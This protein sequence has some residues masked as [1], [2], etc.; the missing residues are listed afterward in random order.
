MKHRFSPHL[1]L[2]LGLL[3]APRSAHTQPSP[4]GSSL[5][6][7]SSKGI[8]GDS[9]NSKDFGKL[10]TNI[11]SDSLTVN[12]K[13]RV[14]T[15][16]G[17]VVVTQGDLTLTSKTVDGTY[18]EDNQIQKIVAR[19]DVVITKQDIKTTSQLAIYDAVTSIITLTDNPQLQQGESVLIAD[20]IK[21][22]LKEDRSE[23][24]GDVRV[25]FVKKE[26]TPLPAGTPGA[27]PSG[28]PSAITTPQGTPGATTPPAA[29]GAVSSAAPM[30]TPIA[31]ALPS[32]PDSTPIVADAKTAS[33]P[34]PEKTIAPKAATKSKAETKTQAKA[35]ATPKPKAASKTNAKSKQK[36]PKTKAQPTSAPQPAE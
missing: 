27:H 9:V 22:Y 15:Y 31:S 1:F 8:L 11:T 7:L 14:F 30:P 33:T 29:P 18:S 34:K 12:S 17:H 32:E 13:T 35:K 6:A 4:G 24:E 2:V 10:P 16:K 5:S 19:G 25:T 26:G 28:T 21:V 20:R 23:A 3:L 36:A